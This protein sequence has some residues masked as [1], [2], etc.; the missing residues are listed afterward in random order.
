MADMLSR[1]QYEEFEE[2]RVEAHDV[3]ELPEFQEGMYSGDLLIIGRY[4]S[5]LEK[6][7]SWTREELEKIRKKS[8][9]FLLKGGYL[10]RYS[11]N[12]SRIPLRVIGDEATKA[13]V[14]HESHD[15]ESAGHRGIQG[16]YERIRGLY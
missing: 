10:W 1:A 7:P 16:T 13:K 3:E 9:G 5:T 4:L 12:P 2:Y 8:Y 6:D 11:K 14:L 15:A